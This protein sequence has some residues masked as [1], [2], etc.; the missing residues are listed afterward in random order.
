MA[1]I[2]KP[3]PE[4]RLAV[5][6]SGGRD[7]SVL[8]DLLSQHPEQPSVLAFHIHHGLQAQA[9]AWVPHCESFCRQRGIALYVRHVQV[10]PEGQGTEAAARDARYA[11]LK[12]LARELQ[13]TVVA[14]AHHAHDQ[15]ETALFNLAR[16]AGSSGL[17]AM[18]F[19][20][21]DG[22]I[23]WWRPL[24]ETSTDEI[25]AYAEKKQLSWI[26]DPSNQDL[27]YSRNRIRHEVLPA[28]Q[29][30]VPGALKG[31]AR[32]VRHAQGAAEL[33]RQAGDYVLSHIMDRQC[34]ICIKTLEQ[35]PAQLRNAT[36]RA[37]CMTLRVAIPSEVQLQE[38]WRQ[39]TESRS[40][41]QM[42][43]AWDRRR[44]AS[45]R[46]YRGRI[47]LVSKLGTADKTEH[48]DAVFS[49]L[50]QSHWQPQGWPGYFSFEPVD[51]FGISRRILEQ[52]PL[53]ARPRRGGERLC[54]WPH[55]H[56]RSL[57]HWYQA[58]AI[59]SWQR[60][61]APLLFLQDQLLFVP[62]VG[63]AAEFCASG[64]DHWV[65]DWVPG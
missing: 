23:T 33:E 48:T 47:Y 17:A 18:P 7:S 41:S 43:I 53:S 24:L 14:L 15:A 20:R 57:K 12:E 54:V 10:R 28:L 59:P 38:W 60:D 37:W 39:L 19:C 49:W 50:G 55:R 22:D 5:A 27:G 65:I 51:G 46:R 52:Y 40:D 29:L 44:G 30:A 36:L 21:V 61:S 58:C 11:A 35:M 45:F 26:E 42:S 63:M 34:S 4:Q 56:H 8:L 1:N 2:R 6:F 3:P 62:G 25:A 31:I 16:G 9:D 64:P 13:V 32:A